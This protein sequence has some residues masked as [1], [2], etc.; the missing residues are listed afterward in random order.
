MYKINLSVLC[1]K[2]C[3]KQKFLFVLRNP[4]L[5][6]MKNKKDEDKKYSPA[7]SDLKLNGS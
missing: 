1:V 4:T 6:Q 5:S 7:N 3:K 2:I